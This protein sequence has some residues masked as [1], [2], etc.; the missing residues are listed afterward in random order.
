M[1][2]DDDVVLGVNKNESN[3]SYTERRGLNR[4]PSSNRG[5]ALSKIRLSGFTM[6][7]IFLMNMLDYYIFN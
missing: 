2:P 7:V 5:L 6:R 1:H 3:P 4:P